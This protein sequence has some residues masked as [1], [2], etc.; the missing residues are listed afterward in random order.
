MKSNQSHPY[1]EAR[2]DPP[3]PPGRLSASM[4]R[5]FL[6]GPYIE[7]ELT[8]EWPYVTCDMIESEYAEYR[9]PGVDSAIRRN[10]DA[11]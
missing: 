9:K 1:P 7:P 2:I 3:N 10:G 5:V 11:A 4:T 6:S 8:G